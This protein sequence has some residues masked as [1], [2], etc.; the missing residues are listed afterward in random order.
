MDV[1]A[2]TIYA[3]RQLEYNI[4]R[5]AVKQLRS[6]IETA[7][8]VTLTG[9][10][11][12]FGVAQLGASLLQSVGCH[13]TAIHTTDLLHGGLGTALMAKSNVVIFISHSGETAEVLEAQRIV[14]GR[15]WGTVITAAVTGNQQSELFERCTIAL[16]Y[17]IDEDGSIHGTI[18]TVSVAVQLVIINALVC[19]MANLLTPQELGA[20]HPGGTLHEKYEEKIHND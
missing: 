5:E 6:A 4:D 3:L 15:A 13:A 18:P 8:V 14:E 2:K 9:V 10:G 16:G 19:D 17:K 20:C 1:I 11:K 12:S 7:H